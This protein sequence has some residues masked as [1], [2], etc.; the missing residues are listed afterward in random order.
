MDFSFFK[1]LTT[2]KNSKRNKKVT[3]TKDVINGII[4]YSKIHHPNEGILILGGQRKKEEISIDNLVIPPFSTHGPFYSGFP[5]N[6][7][8]FD[9]KYVGSAH[10]HPSGSARPSVEDLNHF[11]GLI[12]IIICYPYEEE[13]IHAYDSNGKEVFLYKKI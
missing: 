11:Y 4:S 13:N 8:P 6:E 10:S 3:I 7:L 2:N 5:L 1:K 9:L 12:S